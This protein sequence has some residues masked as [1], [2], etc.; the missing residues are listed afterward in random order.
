MEPDDEG[1]TIGGEPAQPG[2]R[3]QPVRGE[4]RLVLKAHRVE[5]E[6]APY[7]WLLAMLA[8]VFLVEGVVA[9]PSDFVRVVLTGLIA[10][11]TV[12]ALHVAHARRAVR[13]AGAVLAVAL[14][15]TTLIEAVTGNV[16][17][18]TVALANAFLVALAPA[19][20]LIGVIRRL[21]AVRAVTV[22]AVIGVLSV[23]LLIG[24]FFA[25]VYLAIDRIGSPPFFAQE[26]TATM[27]RCQYFSFTTLATVGYGDLTAR[28]NL[29]HTLS[30]F[31]AIL[32]Q[33]YLVTVVALIVGNL[34]RGRRE[35]AAA[36]ADAIEPPPAPGA[37]P[38]QVR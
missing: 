12:L 24:M 18:A 30:N 32:G 3:A 14:V 5:P 9:K 27:S 17:D 4:G 13:T 31:E 33:V 35:R 28:S 25:F 1:S 15:A 29:G 22:E 19:A 38:G 2:A 36:A 21:T 11:T 23:Y 37:P 10:T 8:T 20:I 7:A 26:V 16:D 6:L 34:G